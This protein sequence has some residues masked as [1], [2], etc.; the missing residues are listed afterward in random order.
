MLRTE[1]NMIDF[2]WLASSILFAADAYAEKMHAYACLESKSYLIYD[3]RYQHAQ[4][5]RN[6][7]L[8]HLG[9]A[10]R[11]NRWNRVAGTA[12]PKRP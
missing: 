2:P 10:P 5:H 9:Q 8:A 6:P 3:Q 7:R 4:R 1:N 12:P 11:H